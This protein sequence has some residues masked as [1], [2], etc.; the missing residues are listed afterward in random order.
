MQM[1]EKYIITLECN[2]TALAE[3]IATGLERHATITKVEAAHEKASVKLAAV[4]GSKS[5]PEPVLRGAFH[6]GPKAPYKPKFQRNVTGWM[7]YKVAVASFHP[8]KTF[9]SSDLRSECERNGMTMTNNSSAA[10]LNRLRDAG[11]VRIVGGEG[12]RGYVYSV[13]RDL[14]KPEF[15]R[16]MTNGR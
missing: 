6:P 3:L 10:H 4:A 1:S 9:K 12:R 14:G 15:Q 11:L 7:A 16:T 5:A 8:Q 2:K 13:A